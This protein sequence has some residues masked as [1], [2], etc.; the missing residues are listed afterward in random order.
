MIITLTIKANLAVLNTCIQSDF[1]GIFQIPSLPFIDFEKYLRINLILDYFL[2]STTCNNC[3]YSSTVKQH[4][5]FSQGHLVWTIRYN[6]GR[7]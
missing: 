4:S 7:T 5:Q 6:Q 1:L 2:L 3:A